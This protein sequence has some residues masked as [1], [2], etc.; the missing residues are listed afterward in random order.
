M[1]HIAIQ[2]ALNGKPVDWME[3]VSDEPVPYLLGKHERRNRIR[4]FPG[5]LISLDI[6][7][8]NLTET[9]N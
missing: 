9:D 2:E 3:K 6:F 1:R 4:G 5:F 7:A 8:V